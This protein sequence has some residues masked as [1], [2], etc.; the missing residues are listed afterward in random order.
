MMWCVKYGILYALYACVT[1]Q[2]SVVVYNMGMSDLPEIY[3]QA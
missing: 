3:A 1:V 2:L